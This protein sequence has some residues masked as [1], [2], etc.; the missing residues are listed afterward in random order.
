MKLEAF[1]YNLRHKT[2]PFAQ[3]VLMNN[4]THVPMV[5]TYNKNGIES[6]SE[7]VDLFSSQD[8]N[9][10]FGIIEQYLKDAKAKAYVLITDAY[11]KKISKE[12]YEGMSSKQ[13]D[14][15]AELGI[16]NENDSIECLSVSWG[17]K[18]EVES[19]G[20]ISSPYK[21]DDGVLVI[22]YEN[23]VDTYDD[24]TSAQGRA[25]GLLR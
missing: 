17:Y 24:E 19:G 14:M 2:V 21:K 13:L 8:K 6:A 12:D 16:A 15:M 4:G 5:L 7:L 9:I 18:N 23:I 3:T 22:D 11:M 1:E 25:I 20:I 10:I